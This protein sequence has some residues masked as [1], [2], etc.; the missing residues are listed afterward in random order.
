MA[1]VSVVLLTTDVKELQV[2]LLIFG[3]VCKSAKQ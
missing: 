1:G 2:V 3:S